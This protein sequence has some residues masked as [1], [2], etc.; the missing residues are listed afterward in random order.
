MIMIV[1]DKKEEKGKSCKSE[2]AKTPYEP[3]SRGGSAGCP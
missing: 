1:V 3:T 2:D